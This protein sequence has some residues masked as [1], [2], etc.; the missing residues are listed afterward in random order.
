MEIKAS[1][2]TRNVPT[3]AARPSSA[4]E[5]RDKYP[6][7]G[8]QKGREHTPRPPGKGS[9]HEAPQRAKYSDFRGISD[10]PQKAPIIGKESAPV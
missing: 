8:A 10:T 7:V 3:P 1:R 4:Q 5:G 2:A 9:T 6:R